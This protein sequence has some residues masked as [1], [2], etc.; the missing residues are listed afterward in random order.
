MKSIRLLGNLYC[1]LLLGLMNSC[2]SND[3]E[4]TPIPQS[5]VQCDL[6]QVPYA[7]LS[8]YRFF[9]GELKNLTPAIGV[10]PYQPSSELFTDYALKKRFV[11]MPN[12][13]KAT[14]IS[15][16]EVLDLPVG[17]ALIKVFYYNTVMPGLT[18]KIIETRVMIRKSSGW[19]FAEYIWNPE[20]TEAF[21]E[22]ASTS[23][24]LTI[25]QGSE[26]LTFN[27]RTPNTTV[28]C[29]RCHGDLVT[30]QK[31]PIGIK[32]QNLNWNYSG[33]Q[34]QLTQWINAG[35]LE[36]NLP[37]SIT[38][39]PNYN[40]TALPVTERVRAYFDA[41]CAH[42]HRTGGEAQV[43][44][45][46]MEYTDTSDPENMGV[47]V[48]ALHTLPGYNGRI[49]QPNNVGQSILHYRM[50]TTTDMFYIMPAIGRS[51]QHREG[52]Q[53]VEQWINSF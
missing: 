39:V 43:H 4:Y 9:E 27:Y 49:V 32:P 23:R 6:T 30:Q 48:G 22:T 29:N 18:T 42:C 31:T 13:T 37:S 52:V 14:Y 21:L 1:L 10:L 50:Q 35:Y 51:V 45:L 3:A 2:S 36:A 16:R 5:P 28:E 33:T 40:N 11:W 25:Q 7:K 46:R 8:D 20:Q 12:N 17:A 24:T 44:P 47:G 15:D 53:L 38:T 19:I 41:N 26:T 34:N